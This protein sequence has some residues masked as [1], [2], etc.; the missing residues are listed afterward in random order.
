[1]E[2][3]CKEY[4]EKHKGSNLKQCQ[5]NFL[6]KCKLARN[7]IRRSMK[8]CWLKQR[9]FDRDVFSNMKCSVLVRWYIQILFLGTENKFSDKMFYIQCHNRNILIDGIHLSS[10]KIISG[11]QI[12]AYSI[13]SE[14]MNNVISWYQN[15]IKKKKFLYFGFIISTSLH[16]NCTLLLNGYVLCLHIYSIYTKLS[17]IVNN[18]QE[19]EE[20]E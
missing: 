10:T 9:T 8:F 11:S 6:W 20:E 3:M 14:N 1:M 7:C 12:H 17:I 5:K 4:Q 18:W 15:L 19:K 16:Y 2:N 13:T